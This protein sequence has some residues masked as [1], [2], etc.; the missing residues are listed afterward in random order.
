M[1]IYRYKTGQI[2]SSDKNGWHYEYHADGTLKTTGKIVNNQ[3]EGVWKHYRKPGS[4]Y[5]VCSYKLG[6]PD[7]VW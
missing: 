2:L 1:T 3:K 5:K 7:G 6:I 4:I